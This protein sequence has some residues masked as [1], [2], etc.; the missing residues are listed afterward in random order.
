RDE[1]LQTYSTLARMETAAAG[2]W[3]A[4]IAAAWSRC[5]LFESVGWA[6]ELHDESLRLQE[7]LLSGRYPI[8]RAVYAA[9]ADD[10]ARWSGRPRPTDLERLTDAVLLIEAGRRDL[11]RPP[12]GRAGLSVQGEPITIVWGQTSGRLAVFAATQA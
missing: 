11:S 9:F 10:A 4:P 5:S 6:N 2:G 8:S 7:I 3:P 12:S 1:A